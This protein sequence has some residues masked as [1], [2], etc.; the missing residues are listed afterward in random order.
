MEFDEDS[1]Q[2]DAVGVYRHPNQIWAIEPSPLQSDLVITSSQSALTSKK[3]L[4]LYRMPHEARRGGSDEEAEP[5]EDD[6]D[7][8]NQEQHY[9]NGDLLDLET[10][11]SFSFEDPDTFVH[12]VKWHPVSSQVLSLDPLHLTAWTVA[13]AGVKV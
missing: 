11:S 12:S 1:N 9:Q 6:N 3:E 4:V 2:I 5:T 7:Q 8:N 13:E 10:V